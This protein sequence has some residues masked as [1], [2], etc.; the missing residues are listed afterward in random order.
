MSNRAAGSMNP[1]LTN[2]AQGLAV[3]RTSA[4]AEFIAP[5]VPVVA[6]IGQF[7]KWDD[8]NQ[9]QV[10]N[11]LRAVGGAARRLEFAGSDPSYNCKPN[12]LEATIDDSERDSAG[13]DQS[14]LEQ[15]KT[16]TLVGSGTVSHEDA[17]LT[18][19]KAGVTAVAGRG[20]FSNLDIDPIDQIDEQ[21]EAIAT[22][23]GMM[24]NRIVLGLGAWRKLRAH[25]K[26]KGRTGGVKVAGIS[27]QD[28]ASL[29]LNPSIDPRVGVLV[30]STTKMPLTDAKSNIVGDEVFIFFTNPSPSTY[31]ASF[32]KTFRGGRGGGV[33]AVRVYRDDHCRSDVLAVDWSVDVQV[34]STALVRRLTIT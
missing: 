4:L 8:H 3:Q 17:V 30:K 1:H 25:P 11:T 12:A 28:F 21:I 15:S 20:Q 23:T 24:P 33:D 10:V 31:D 19:I 22:A 7:K 29:L 5:S 13:D 34:V 32:A 2:Y 26:V 18:V 14:L 6:T 16:A 9:F 27:L